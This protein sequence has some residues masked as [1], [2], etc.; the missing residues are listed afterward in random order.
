M[1]TL[2]TTENT[3]FPAEDQLVQVRLA[4]IQSLVS[5]FQALGGGWQDNQPQTANTS[6][7][8]HKS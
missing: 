3:L 8:A 1:L 5:L 7:Q 6:D 2:L 4:H